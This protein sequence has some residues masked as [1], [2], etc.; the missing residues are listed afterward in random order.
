MARTANPG[1]TMSQKQVFDDRFVLL[2]SATIDT[3]KTPFI[4]RSNPAV[5]MLDYKT[6][7][8][9]WLSEPSIPTIIFCE[10]SGSPLDELVALTHEFNSRAKKVT[11]LSYKSPERE[12]IR[13]KGYGELGAIHYALTNCK[14]ENSTL[15]VKVTGRYYIENFPDILADMRRSEHAALLS[16]TVHRQKIPS[17]C[18]VSTREFLWNYLVPRRESIDDVAGFYFEHALAEAAAAAKQDGLLHATFSARPKVRGMSGTTNLPQTANKKGNHLS[19]FVTPDYR[20]FFLAVLSETLK[21]GA[22][23]PAA[24]QAHNLYRRLEVAPPPS[25][26]ETAFSL[27]ELNLLDQCIHFCLNGLD[28]N[29]FARRTGFSSEAASLLAEAITQVV[30]TGQSNGSGGHDTNSIPAVVSGTPD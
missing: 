24:Q 29:E 19:F 17:E 9:K 22:S 5:R 16:C 23:N 6:A 8:L 20:H 10:N 12:S 2:L 4:H 30:G 25:D 21:N 27:L 13:G 14:L 7:L 18:F 3:G 28:R 11:F 1:N 15:V 26:T